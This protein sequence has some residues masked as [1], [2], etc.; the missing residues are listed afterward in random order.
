MNGELILERSK[1]SRVLVTGGTGFIGSYVLM[2][3]F[4]RGEE[5]VVFDL[6]PPSVVA[7]NFRDRLIW[8]EGDIRDKCQV[9]ALISKYKPEVII[10][11]AG[12]LQYGCMENPRLAVEVNVLGLTNVLDGAVRYGAK[13]VVTASSAAVY[14]SSRKPVKEN[15]S[16]AF[17]VSLYGATKFL[18]EILC[19]QYIAN[20]GLQATNL[21]YFAV[22]GPGEVRS[23]GIAMVIKEIQKIVTGKSI[24]LSDVKGTDHIQLIFVADAALATVLAATVPGPVSLSYNIA[25]GIENYITFEEFVSIIKEMVPYCG[26][27]IFEGK[28]K[29]RGPMDITLARQELGFEPRFSLRDG[30]R[31][32]IRFYLQGSS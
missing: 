26:H 10:N 5:P 4:Q 27:V 8:I 14:G 24:T 30:L 16:I 29:D 6:E 17:D 23:P 25:G 22:F 12:L 11:L 1:K 20:Y 21:R 9:D 3:L 32:T 19:R 31:E 28:G 13:R 18:G 2:E 7:K 15:D